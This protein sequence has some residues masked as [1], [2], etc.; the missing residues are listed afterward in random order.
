MPIELRGR[1]PGSSNMRPAYSDAVLARQ[2]ADYGPIPKLRVPDPAWISQTAREFEEDGL[3]SALVAH[4]SS[5][6]D[7]WAVCTWALAATTRLRLVAAHRVGLQLP[8]SGARAIATLDAL[9]GG[10][11]MIHAIQ[12][13]TEEDQW[14]EGD[15]VDKATRYKRAG[16]YFDVFKRLLT[17]D[18]P[19]D[20]SG[21]FYRVKG[22][23]SS[24]KP[25]QKPYPTISGAGA[26]V[27]G[28]A[29]CARHV[30]VYALTAEPLESTAELLARVRAA[31]A[32]EGRSLRFWRDCNFIV[33]PTDEAAWRK[34]EAITAEL[35]HAGSGQRVWE[36]GDK[37][38]L[39]PQSV[40]QQRVL[41]ASSQGERVGKAMYTAI[42]KLAA[43][44]VA[45]SFVGS[46]ETVA[47]AV[48]DYYDLG[49]EIFSIGIAVVTDEDREMRKALIGCLR[50]G[51]A[52]RDR[53]AR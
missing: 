28:L 47:D 29:F 8:V 21:D 40:A 44:T 5:W 26:S 2:A 19:F 10:R 7:V 32:Q 18:E 35:T 33:A 50:R 34:A 36:Q 38:T 6:P 51:A 31:A 27:E 15:F 20:Y 48:L 42:S 53:R 12:G 39:Q 43:G 16:E 41:A 25:V 52:E 46:P 11:V 4:R 9:S 30:D 14:R 37:A 49:I 24:F 17:S 22:A 45:S 1:L 13:N 23:W 3:D